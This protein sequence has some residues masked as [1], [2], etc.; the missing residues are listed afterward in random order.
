MTR[1]FIIKYSYMYIGYHLQ[2]ITGC[3]L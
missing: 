3:M 2:I 1:H